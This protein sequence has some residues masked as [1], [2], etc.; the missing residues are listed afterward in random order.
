[1]S[2]AT[3]VYRTVH[4]SGM[5]IAFIDKG[6]GTQIGIPRDRYEANGYQPPFESLPQK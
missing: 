6:V 2:E 4:T 5:E 3:G 1:M